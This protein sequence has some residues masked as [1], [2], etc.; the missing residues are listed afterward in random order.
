MD[1]PHCDLVLR[2]NKPDNFSSYMQA[3]GRA[4]AKQDA[5]Y[6]LLIDQ[7]D[8]E[9]LKKTRDEFKQYDLIEQVNTI[10]RIQS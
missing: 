6:V 1:I 5:R 2:F 10:H 8:P 9:E 7:S 4:R 3:K